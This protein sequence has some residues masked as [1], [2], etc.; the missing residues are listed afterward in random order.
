MLWFFYLSE[1]WSNLVEFHRIWPKSIKFDWICNF[2]PTY[3]STLDTSRVHSPDIRS[4]GFRYKLRKLE[5]PRKSIFRWKIRFPK[6]DSRM[7]GFENCKRFVKSHN[8][9]KNA[10]NYIN[11]FKCAIN[12]MVGR[13]WNIA[14]SSTHTPYNVSW[15]ISILGYSTGA[16]NTF[17]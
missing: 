11:Y 10:V 4:L 3:R 15:I 13:T 5:T 1:I 2:A 8:Q 9:L 14:S 12:P 16:S 6:D 17:N 7:S